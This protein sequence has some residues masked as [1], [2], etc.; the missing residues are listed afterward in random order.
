MRHS[1][2]RVPFAEIMDMATVSKGGDT[3]TV[4]KYFAKRYDT[5]TAVV[6]P[7]HGEL[8]DMR[9]PYALKGVVIAGMKCL[10]LNTSAPGPA[11][12]TNGP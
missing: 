3:W 11:E 8:A 12:P 2:T 7:T 6:P 5:T 1:F 10:P 4:D 9:S